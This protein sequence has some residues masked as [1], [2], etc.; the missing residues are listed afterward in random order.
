VDKWQSSFA[1][2]LANDL[3]TTTTTPDHIL[4]ID[5]GGTGIKAAIVD[6][7]FGKIVSD[8][9]REPTPQ[10]ATVRAVVD[11]LTK[12]ARRYDWNG[13]IGCGFPGVV[14]SGTVYSAA[15]LL[16]EWVGVNLAYIISKESSRDA[17]VINDADAAGL[18]EMQFGSVPGRNCQGG[19]V[20]LLVTLGT[21]IGTA[22][23]VDGLLVPNTELGHIEIDGQD[24]ERLAATVVREREDLSWE[25]WSSRVN[26]YLR[27]LERLLSPDCFII[28][29]GISDSPEKLFPHLHIATPIIPAQLGSNAGIIGAALFA[30]RI[31]PKKIGSEIC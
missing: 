12:A 22:M 9:F 8:V 30:A 18:A 3:M 5:I 14:K 11:L 29:G 23:F 28:G 13:R 6:T 20:V 16:G 10:P 2:K 21:G 26:Q 1:R 25:S 4:G 15:N 31:N 17:A 7:T 24:A 19:R 27:R